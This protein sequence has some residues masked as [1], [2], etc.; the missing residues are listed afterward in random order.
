M[1]SLREPEDR[2]IPAECNGKASGERQLIDAYFGWESVPAMNQSSIAMHKCCWCY[3]AILSTI[4]QRSIVVETPGSQ[5][6]STL[7]LNC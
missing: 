4:W 6:P 2:S 7:T 5:A 1:D 3:L